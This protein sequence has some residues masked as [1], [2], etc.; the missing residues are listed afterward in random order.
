MSDREK[1]S[2][3]EV[4]MFLAF[5]FSIVGESE[6][7]AIKEVFRLAEILSVTAG[8]NVRA[9]KMNRQGSTIVIVLDGLVSGFL[10][11]QTNHRTDIWLGKTRSVLINDGSL[12][13]L[14]AFNIEAIEDSLLMLISKEKLEVICQT[15]PV[16]N[17][18]FAEFIFPAT[19]K[20][21]EY[22]SIL[23]KID[24]PANKFSYFKRAFPKVWYSVPIR[25]YNSYVGN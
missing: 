1:N 7:Q 6:S 10:A 18:L 19:I 15:Y 3:G 9:E 22:H 16:L 4:R 11:R 17:R 24:H 13:N 5:L 12:Q 25:I 21:L 14:E 23:N 20:S 2:I 8:D